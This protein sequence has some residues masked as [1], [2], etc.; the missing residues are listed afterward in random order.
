MQQPL[1]MGYYISTAPAGPLPS[2]FWSTCPQAST[3]YPVCLKSA[4]H[5]QASLVGGLDDA[6]AGGGTTTSTSTGS[7]VTGHHLLDST[8]TCDV[9]RYVLESYNAL[10]WLTI[11]PVTNDRRSCL[12]VHVLILSQLYQA[13][14]ALS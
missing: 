1:A 8:H 5:L 12:P 11:S 4:L 6:V 9:L 3:Q 14:Q 10:S 2:W 13:L 7:A